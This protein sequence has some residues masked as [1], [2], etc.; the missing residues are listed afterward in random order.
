MGR[1]AVSPRPT[2]TRR[3]R[4]AEHRWVALRSSLLQAAWNYETLQGV[5]FAWSL[6]PALDRLYPD[7]EARARRLHA[8]LDIFN[9][10][11]YLASLGM[12]VAL[13]IEEEIARSGA[14]VSEQR[15]ARLLKALR[16]TLGALGDELFWA[17]WRPAIGLT[18]VVAALIAPSLWAALLFLVVY[19]ALAQT[20][21]W[22]GVRTGFA[23]GAGIAR[24]LQNPFW[25][26]A[27]EAAKTGGATAAGAA[28]G[29]GVALSSGGGGARGA[30]VFSIIVALFWVVGLRAGRRGQPLSPSLAYLAVVILLS[31][32]FH[33]RPGAV[34]W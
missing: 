7:R 12:G 20:V 31:A 34:P 24:V 22:R 4:A 3:P 16:G 15:L 5:G 25:R 26:R 21:R 27:I 29:A 1:G 19:N 6:L 30:G 33:L 17:A 9:S 2:S 28:F 13:R 32:L 11:P 23:S 14:A 18:A 10:N 8:H